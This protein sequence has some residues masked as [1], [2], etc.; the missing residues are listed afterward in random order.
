MV[1]CTA[2][3]QCTSFVICQSEQPPRSLLRV[4]GGLRN[5]RRHHIKQE[6]PNT[7]QQAPLAVQPPALPNNRSHWQSMQDA[8]H[9][10]SMYKRRSSLSFP[11]GLQRSLVAL[12]V[13]PVLHEPGDAVGRAAWQAKGLGITTHDAVVLDGA[14]EPGDVPR[15]RRH[16]QGACDASCIARR[17]A[18]QA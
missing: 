14:R 7:T 11:S 16:L 15:A 13:L 9:R 4:Q 17:V 6:T 10:P 12:G 18:I 1:H 3:V 2:A 8:Q 5:P